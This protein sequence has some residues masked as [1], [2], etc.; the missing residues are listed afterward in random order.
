MFKI[1]RNADCKDGPQ[2]PR[3]WRGKKDGL[4]ESASHVMDE[5]GRIYGAGRQYWGTAGFGDPEMTSHMSPL[6]ANYP[7]LYE[8]AVFRALEAPTGFL[9]MVSGEFSTM[10]LHRSGQIWGWGEGYQG[11]CAFGLPNGSGSY[12]YEWRDGP[13]VNPDVMAIFF[14]PT[15][16]APGYLFKD[17]GHD[18]YTT[19]GVGKEDGRLYFWGSDNILLTLDR[20]YEP[21]LVPQLTKRCKFVDGSMITYAVVTED[22]EVYAMGRWWFTEGSGENEWDFS[23]ETPLWKVEGLPEGA[24]I[25]DLAVGYSLLVVL[26]DNGQV[27]Y[28]GRNDYHSGIDPDD[29]EY[30]EMLYEFKQ[31]IALDHV[32]IQS[33]KASDFSTMIF[34]DSENRAYQTTT[35]WYTSGLENPCSPNYWDPHLMFGGW[36][37]RDFW[38]NTYYPSRFMID[39]NG[40]LWSWGWNY[41]GALGIGAGR[42]DLSGYWPHLQAFPCARQY[43]AEA[44][45]LYGQPTGLNSW[46]FVGVSPYAP[47]PRAYKR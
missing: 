12:R 6:G 35:G 21:T 44:V 5:D 45:N 36:P 18:F 7:E 26:L 39:I 29:P 22:N 16:C 8:S 34:I 25:V 42:M 31:I 19:L 2:Y 47:V 40:L 33:I 41:S 1:I 38:M 11:N 20:V 17:I 9:K 27:W 15:E 37:V 30:G 4:L 28:A 32:K 24:V 23:E 3:W 13:H 43:C 10:A 46:R 14:A